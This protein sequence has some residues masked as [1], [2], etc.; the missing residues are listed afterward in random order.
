MNETSFTNLAKHFVKEWYRNRDI[1]MVGEPYIVWL[2]KTLQNSK[3][4]L[5]SDT[6]DGRYFEVTYNGDKKEIY[7]DA[8]KKESNQCISENAVKKEGA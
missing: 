2:C 1:E 3:A 4:L 7:I 8:Y 6:P 5:S